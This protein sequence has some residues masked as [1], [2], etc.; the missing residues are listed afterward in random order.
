M[1]AFG[2]A[3]HVAPAANSALEATSAFIVRLRQLSDM[4]DQQLARVEQACAATRTVERRCD[5]IEEADQD[6]LHV[7]LEGWA[8]RYHA[9]E[10]GRRQCSALVLPG[11]VGDLDRLMLGSVDFGLLALTSCRVALLPVSELRAMVEVDRALRQALWKLMAIENAAAN[12]RLL[13]LGRRTARERLAHLICETAMRLPP[14]GARPAMSFEFPPTQA[15][16]A[17]A[18]GLS[19]VHVNRSLQ[20]L[21]KEGAIRLSGGLLTILN[22]PAL[23]QAAQFS[24]GYLHLARSHAVALATVE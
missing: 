1:S 4:T 8:A 23:C 2:T 15:D 20:L 10:D 13:S 6:C 22:W 9:L 11:D 19:P 3:R 24:A 21:R 16:L 14:D 7:V 5:V 18:L 12:E 17:D